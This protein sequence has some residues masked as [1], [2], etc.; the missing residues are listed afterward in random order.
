MSKKGFAILSAIITVVVAIVVFYGVIKPKTITT[1]NHETK[2]T[3][4]DVKIALV[5]EDNGTVYNGDNVRMSD[6]LLKTLKENTEYK[7]ETV[8]RSIAE[9]GLENGNY[10]MMV[11]LPSK[12]SENVLSLESKDPKQA[13]FQYKI[14]SDKQT[15][16]KQAEQ[17]VAELKN[18]FNKGMIN[19]YFSSIIGNL[20][21][22]QTQ[23]GAAVG[24]E[25]NAL[26]KYQSDLMAP[27]T[28]YSTQF[29]GL[30]NNSDSLISSYSNFNKSINNTNEAFTS[31]IDTN[32]T[33]DQEIDKIKI[34]QEAWQTS[35]K[36]REDN[37]KNYDESFKKLSVTEQLESLKTTQKYIN[38]NLINSPI[39]NDMEERARGFNKSI[40]STTEMFTNMN[41]NVSDVL[42]TYKQRIDAAIEESLKKRKNREAEEKTVGLLVKDLKEG[43]LSKVS[44]AVRNLPHYDSSTIDELKISSADKN[45][46]KKIN[47][48]AEKYAKKYNIPLS[49]RNQTLSQ[50]RLDELK[51]VVETNLKNRQNFTFSPRQGKYNKVT[52]S[53]NSEYKLVNVESSY[54]VVKRESDNQ[55][56]I[57]FNE[58]V[59]EVQISY[60]LDYKNDVLMMTPAAVEAKASVV[61]K[62]NVAKEKEEEIETTDENGN[63]VKQKKKVYDPEETEFLNEFNQSKVVF[64]FE[65]SFNIEA[66][67][68]AIYNDLR[69]YHQLF[70]IVKTI[71]G[72]DVNSDNF[73]SLEPKEDSLLKKA[74]LKDIN[75][76]LTSL[77]SKT[78]VDQ[79]RNGL[80]VPQDKFKELDSIKINSDQLEKVVKELKQAIKTFSSTIDSAV[81]ETEKIYKTLEEKPEFKDSEKRDNT[82]LVTVSAN[83][84]KDLVKLMSASNKLLS[85]T[86]SNQSTAEEINRGFEGLGNRVENLEQEGTD[87]TG[88]VNDLKSNMEKDY[89]SN[90]EFLKS[91]S[92]VLS[93]TKDGNEKNKAVYDY[94]SNPVDAGNVDKLLSE[95]NA[96]KTAIKQDTRTGIIVI[97]IIYLVSILIAHML[98]SMDFS[99]LQIQKYTTRVQWKN[100]MVPMTLMFGLSLIL[101]IIIGIIT[102]AKLDLSFDK[103]I[104]LIF[105]IFILTVL[106]TGLNNWLL[107]RIKSSGLLV[108]LSILILYIVT[109]GQLLDERTAANEVLSYISPLNYIENSLTLF[110]N[111]QEGW[112]I[113]FGI[114]LIVSIIFSVLNAVE[115]R[116]LKNM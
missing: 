92:K 106:F 87:L 79:L 93:N 22:A 68:T 67:N 6:F 89:G 9:K 77:M 113:I 43:M 23:V 36:T 74:E 12:F 60:G 63:K 107:Y 61:K 48:F 28:N 29:K 3:N 31:I 27:L 38:E 90:E 30:N 115:Y 55:V 58:P 45:Y 20:Q 94:L 64:P 16:V 37:L 66:S 76:I 100:S 75:K 109:T 85:N 10:N 104:A 84:N 72:L 114:S 116:K 86:K 1:G 95:S 52:L 51:K 35:M 62:V 59:D 34:L 108:S 7:L 18:L 91:F 32:K 8:T 21:T 56:S 11:I 42:N 73:D 14:K 50:Q 65:S 25:R 102:G 110:L 97:M 26:N 39:F 103:T 111:N 88:K 54:G 69:N 57:T 78:I 13:I 2:I 15:I 53:V 4:N 46:L 44:E 41:N 5:N 19:V 96:P 24:R 70:S 81:K 71:Y 33:Y 49:T 112:G 80:T 47:L 99:K 98:Q 83:I 101:S 17:T 82:D 105:L 40:A